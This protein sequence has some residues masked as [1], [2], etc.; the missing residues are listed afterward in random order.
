MILLGPTKRPTAAECR[1]S[2][3][4]LGLELDLDPG[5]VGPNIVTLVSSMFKYLPSNW[6]GGKCRH[7]NR[8]FDALQVATVD[9]ISSNSSNRM[10]IRAKIMLFQDQEEGRKMHS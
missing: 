9:K 4:L 2:L 7:H 10:I 8:V 5:L 1:V 3:E 6:T